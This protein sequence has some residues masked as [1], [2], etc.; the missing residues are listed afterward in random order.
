MR[1]LLSLFASENRCSLC[2][3]MPARSMS[4][5]S[6]SYAHCK[7]QLLVVTVSVPFLLLK[8][9]VSGIQKVNVSLCMIA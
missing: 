9:A 5:D 2:V 6:Q 1:Q 8:K 4:G 7:G 3:Y